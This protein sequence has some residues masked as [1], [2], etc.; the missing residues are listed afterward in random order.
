[1][2]CGVYPTSLFPVRSASLFTGTAS[3]PE[4]IYDGAVGRRLASTVYAFDHLALLHVPFHSLVQDLSTG[5]V[6]IQ[7]PIITVRKDL[8]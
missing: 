1:M 6:R 7:Y 3:S 2:Y 4:S 8:A 5:M